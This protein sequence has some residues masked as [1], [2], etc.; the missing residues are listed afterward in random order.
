MTTDP[1]VPVPLRRLIQQP[2]RPRIGRRRQIIVS[3]EQ[4]E[5]W[6]EAAAELGISVSEMIRNATDKEAAKAI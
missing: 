2:G 6:Q 1:L 4:W 5:R 3:D